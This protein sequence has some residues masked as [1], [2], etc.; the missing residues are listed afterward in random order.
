M[1]S[2][3]KEENTGSTGESGD[4]SWG[5]DFGGRD[6]RWIDKYGID[7]AVYT[8]F[9]GMFASEALMG[10]LDGSINPSGRLPDTF[11]LDYYDIPS[12][13]NFLNFKND[14]PVL[15]TD[16]PAYS[17]ICYEEGMYVG[18]RYFTSFRKPVAYQFGYGLSYTV[19]EKSFSAP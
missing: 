19:F 12:S 9:G 7:A 18:Y 2:G 8:G 5:V 15:Q 4:S 17:D 3:N 10:I 11:A 14:E 1:R 16:Y 6:V 13:K